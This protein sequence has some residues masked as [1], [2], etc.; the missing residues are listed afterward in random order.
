M[1]IISVFSVNRIGKIASLLVIVGIF[2]LVLCCMY[3][4]FQDTLQVRANRSNAMQ[5]SKQ[6]ATE[7]IVPVMAPDFF[8]E[9]RLERDKVRSERSYLLREII[10]NATSQDTKQQAQES[11]IKM[12]L[13]KQREMEMENLI[14]AKGFSDALV[15]IR[16][17]SV[18][19]VVKTSS[20]TREEVIQVADVISRISG[21]KPGD[22]T[23]SAK[24]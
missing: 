6:L 14:K 23:V 7:Q 5:V 13:E 4:L 3:T 10:Q 11:I 22:I 24:P 20:L 19:A 15:F 2:L 18:S 17:N 9:Y 8:T 21:V 12:T 1:K 16:D